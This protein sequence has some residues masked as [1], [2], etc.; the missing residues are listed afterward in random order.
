MVFWGAKPKGKLGWNIA[1]LC[2]CKATEIKMYK[3]RKKKEEYTDRIIIP[4]LSEAQ[5]L[6]VWKLCWGLFDQHQSEIMYEKKASY[7]I[8]CE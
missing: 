8:W 1:D 2:T 5:V 4:A 6:A 3:K 7:V